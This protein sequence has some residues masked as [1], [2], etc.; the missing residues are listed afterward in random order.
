MAGKCKMVIMF[1][2]TVSAGVKSLNI[3]LGGT[4]EL[5]KYKQ[6]SRF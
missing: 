2:Y 3:P 1:F 4:V 6:P 5:P